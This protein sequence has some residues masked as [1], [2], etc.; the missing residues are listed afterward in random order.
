MLNVSSALKGLSEEEFK[1]HFHYI[2]TDKLIKIIS[3]AYEKCCLNLFEGKLKSGV[4]SFVA[5][6]KGAVCVDFGDFETSLL[7]AI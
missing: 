4:I 5:A 3:V 1:K 2:Y 7:L 6:C